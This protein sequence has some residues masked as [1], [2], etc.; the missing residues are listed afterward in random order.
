MERS[1]LYRFLARVGRGSTRLSLF[2][3]LRRFVRHAREL[4]GRERA[5]IRAEIA[6]IPG[7]MALL[8]KPRNGERWSAED[9]MQLRN[10]MR[11]LGTLGLYLGTLAIPGTVLTLPLL[12]WYLD[13]RVERRRRLANADRTGTEPA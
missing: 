8:M 7:L 3:R 4:N 11:G 12:A 2:G 10:Q 6:R 9:R 1:T 13:R 5:R